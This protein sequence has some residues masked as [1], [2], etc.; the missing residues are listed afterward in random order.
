MGGLG[1]ALISHSYRH[2]YIN[3]FIKVHKEFPLSILAPT[4]LSLGRQDLPVLFPW[5]RI[6]PQFPSPDEGLQEMVFRWEEAESAPRSLLGCCQNGTIEVHVTPYA[7]VCCLLSIFPQE[8]SIF[9]SVSE[10]EA[11]ESHT[12]RCVLGSELCPSMVAF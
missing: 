4:R 12:L 5:P 11:Q 8:Y 2:A 10:P 7:L 6:C 3:I 1:V 9:L